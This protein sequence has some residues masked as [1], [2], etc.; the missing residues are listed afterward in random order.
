MNKEEAITAIEKG[1]D[2]QKLESIALQRIKDGA[3]F[4]E[5]CNLTEHMENI[6]AGTPSK[7]HFTF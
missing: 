7:L 4:D 3:R 2:I 1:E 6:K 5:I